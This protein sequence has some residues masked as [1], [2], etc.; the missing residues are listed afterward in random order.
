[1]VLDD[2][3]HG[4]RR[5][6]QLIL[7][8]FPPFSQSLSSISGTAWMFSRVMADLGP[9]RECVTWRSFTVGVMDSKGRVLLVP[10]SVDCGLKRNIPARETVPVLL[11]HLDAPAG[12]FPVTLIGH[13]KEI[14]FFRRNCLLCGRVHS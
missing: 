9:S 13:G 8:I 3:E 4:G 6:P 1:M 7:P 5:Q 10:D 14:P 12:L 11:L 2:P